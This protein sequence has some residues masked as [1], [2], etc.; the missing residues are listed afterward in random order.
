MRGVVMVL[1]A[2]DHVRVYSAIPAGGPSPGVFFTRWVTHFV[3]PGFAF[4]AGTA[5]FL[6][7]RKLGSRGALARYLVSRGIILVLLELTVIR[8]SWTFNFDYA[9]YVL[10]GVIWMLGWCMILLAALIWLPTPAIAIIG[11]LLVA[12]QNVFGALPPSPLS[13]FLYLGGEVPPI[14]VLYTI[15]PWIGVMAL[16][17]AFGA[18]MV[19]ET[20]EPTT[21]KSAVIPSPI[22]VSRRSRSAGARSS[23]NPK[24]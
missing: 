10:A 2:I 14:H 13:T 18:I 9:H 11:F 22:R 21:R 1:M 20:A 17:Y 8:V 23:N 3:A 15:I 6:H 4:L 5:A 7:G 19:R 16:G 24:P 12:G